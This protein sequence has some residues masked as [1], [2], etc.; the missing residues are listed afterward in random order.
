MNT[1]SAPHIPRPRSLQAPPAPLDLDPLRFRLTLLTIVLNVG[2]VAALTRY[3]GSD[4]K[5]GLAL[6]GFDLLLLGGFAIR[7]RDRFLKHL[8]GFGLVLGMT[9]LAA[10]AWLVDGTRT[11]DYSSGGGPMLWRSPVWMPLAWL[12]VAV[13]FAVMGERLRR[14]R[15]G[16]GVLLTALL[17]AVNIPYYEEMAR[18]IHWW[19]YSNCRMLSGTPYYIIL[20]EFF[21]AGGIALLVDWVRRLEAGRTFLAGLIGGGLIFAS[22]AFAYGVTDRL[23]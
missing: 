21:I 23:W 10:D 15:P 12:V 6:N 19:E 4:W 14:W 17:G 20:G 7:R 2:V 9:E 18:R 3:S 1:A 22:Y 16:W 11:L 13:Q 8:L 5:T